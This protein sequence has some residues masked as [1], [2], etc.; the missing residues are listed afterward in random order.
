MPASAAASSLS[1]CSRSATCAGL[2]R[3]DEHAGDPARARRARPT[4]R[5]RAAPARAAAVADRSPAAAPA[6][7]CSIS[8]RRRGGDVRPGLGEDLGRGAAVARRGAGRRAA[9]R[10]RRCSSRVSRS[11]R[12]SA[13]ATGE[14]RTRSTTARR[15]GSHVVVAVGRPGG[16]PSRHRHGS[17]VTVD[18]AYGAYE[19][20]ALYVGVAPADSHDW[21]DDREGNRGM[22]RRRQLPASPGIPAKSMKGRDPMSD[23]LA[24]PAGRH[25][26]RPHR[27]VAVRAALPA[28]GA[29]VHRDPGGRLPHRQSS[30]AS[31]STRCSNGSAS[32]GRSSAAASAARWHEPGTTPA[33]SW[34][35]WPTTRVLLFT[36]QFAFG[37]WGPNAISDLISAVVAWLPR[38]FVAIDHRGVAAA[39]ASAVRDLITGALG[40]LSYGRLLATVASVFIIGL[41]VIAALNQV[42]IATTVTTAGA[43][44]GARHGR[45]H[46]DRRRRRRAGPADAGAL[47]GLAATGWPPSPR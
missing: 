31:S 35:G 38:A 41:G 32:T 17:S 47:G 8:R 15:P 26:R 36:L 25:R 34:P 6:R 23:P 45:R 33:T 11:P 10:R 42:G 2:G 22:N 44:R 7:R 24:A 20:F 4:C 19:T 5:A 46:P 16:R 13:I 1:P 39:I 3:D 27:H 21:V 18:G 30:S 9:R 12:A 28:E 43:G 14:A 37:V 40:G 29:R